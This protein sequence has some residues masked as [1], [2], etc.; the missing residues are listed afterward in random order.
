MNDAVE[1]AAERKS[2]RHELHRLIRWIR[3]NPDDWERICHLESSDLK[4]EYV[5]SLVERLYQENLY[6]LMLLVIFSSQYRYDISQAINKTNYECF[7]DIPMDTLLERFRKNI[8]MT[9]LE[10]GQC[11]R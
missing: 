1:K 3:D 8:E 5:A 9:A 2:G 11:K 4:S 10:W 6:T 7:L